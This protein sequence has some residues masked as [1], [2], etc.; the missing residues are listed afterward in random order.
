M[1]SDEILL[2]KVFW[3]TLDDLTVLPDDYRVRKR[4]LLSTESFR[5]IAVLSTSFFISVS[6]VKRLPFLC[7]DE[8]DIISIHFTLSQHQENLSDRSRWLTDPAIH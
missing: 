4:G 7:I 2:L 3:I 5:T 1:I 6:S 8:H